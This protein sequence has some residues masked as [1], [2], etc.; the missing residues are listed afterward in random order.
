[1]LFLCYPK[2]S[3]CKKAKKYL[4]LNGIDYVERDIVLDHPKKEELKKWISFNNI[5]INKYFNT[6][7]IMYRQME[8]SKKLKDLTDD[9]KINILSKNGM[10]VKRPL[11]VLDDGKIILGF[12]EEDYS[13]LKR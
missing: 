10:L 13:K 12:K 5:D 2:C 11:I 4:D 3:T 1:M 7:G 8:L 9:E 6:S